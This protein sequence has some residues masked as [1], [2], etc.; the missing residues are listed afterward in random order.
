MKKIAFLALGL[1][2]IGTIGTIKVFSDCFREKLKEAKE[3]QEKLKKEEKEK[4]KEK[5]EVYSFCEY[6]SQ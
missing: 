2:I 1:G 5:E 3:K 6:I 4:M